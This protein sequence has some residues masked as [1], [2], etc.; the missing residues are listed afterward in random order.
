MT[1][2]YRMQYESND[3]MIAR[4]ERSKTREKW[5][6]MA[7]FLMLVWTGIWGT[8]AEVWPEWFA[9]VIGTVTLEIIIGIS[10]MSFGLL[11]GLLT[12]LASLRWI[13]GKLLFAGTKSIIIDPV[14]PESI[15]HTRRCHLCGEV[16]RFW[17]VWDENG[18][19]SHYSKLDPGKWKWCLCSQFRGEEGG[20]E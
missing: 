1:A 11:L 12:F 3:D 19:T 13:T 15:T 16:Q 2:M 20:Y 14:H 10:A 6:I 5:M 9:R 7:A 4:A 8:V 18:P 17:N